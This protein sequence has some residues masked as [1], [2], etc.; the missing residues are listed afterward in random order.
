MAPCIGA[1]SERPA[2]WPD[3]HT[4][5]CRSR[6]KI[7][8]EIV[9]RFVRAMTE[10]TRLVVLQPCALA[11]RP[12]AAGRAIC[13]GGPQTRH[14]HVIDGADAPAMVPLGLDA[15]NA[16]FYGGNCHKWLLAPRRVRLSLPGQGQRGSLAA[17]AGELGFSSRP[18]APGR[19]RR[20]G[21]RPRGCVSTSSKARAIRVP[22]WPSR[23][24]RLS[25]ATRPGTNSRLQCPPGRLRSQPLCRL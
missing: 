1:G 18:P 8:A 6:P 17:V 21:H 10:R 25:G 19:T 20:I 16:D 15:F 12:G 9:R 22:G 7:P 2:A 14:P 11:D 13:A 24:D 4:F 5:R 3:V 23:G